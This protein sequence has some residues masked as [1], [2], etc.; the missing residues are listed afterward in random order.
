MEQTTQLKSYAFL[1]TAVFLFGFTGI[2]GGLISLQESMLV[3]YRM[4]MSA[5]MM[6]VVVLLSGKFRIISFKDLKPILLISG[7]IALHWVTFYG[8]IK[9]ASVSVAMVCLSSITLFTALLEPIILKQRFVKSE[10]L[11]SLLV[12]LGVYIIARAQ[13]GQLTGVI[14]GVIAAILSALFTVLNKKMIVKYDSRLLSFYEL[15]LGFLI[16]TL[17]LPLIHFV[18]PLEQLIPTSMD[19]FYLLLLSLFCTVLAFNLS[20]KALRQLSP[21]T[22]NLVINLEPVY[23]ILLAFVV[24][25]EHKYLNQG[26]AIGAIIIICSVLL[27]TYIRLQRLNIKLTK[28]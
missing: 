15:G 3:W 4:W 20:L 13:E 1:H 26:F 6:F 19:W 16:L 10:V 25:K 27:H 22:V 23:G 21:F 8:S 28:Q 24:L 14:L 11:L 2:L 18:S 17:L 7:L 12:L 5:L 9:Y